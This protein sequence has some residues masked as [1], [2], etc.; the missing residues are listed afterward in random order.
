MSENNKRIKE[1]DVQ[2]NELKNRYE[3]IMDKLK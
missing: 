1:A 3:E 2:G